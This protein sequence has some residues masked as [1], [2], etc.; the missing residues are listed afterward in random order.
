MCFEKVSRTTKTSN[1]DNSFENRLNEESAIIKELTDKNS[2]FNINDIMETR[3]KKA[4]NIIKEDDK[5]VLDDISNAFNKV[6]TYTIALKKCFDTSQQEVSKLTMKSNHIAS[7]NNRQTELWQESTNK[8]YMY[9]FE[10]INL[11][12]S[13]QHE[14][15]NSKRCSSH[16]MNNIE[17]LLHTLP[18]V[19]I[20]LN[21]NEGTRIPNLKVLEVENSQLK[22]EL[23][24]S[25][26][27]FKPSMGQALLKYV[28]KLKEWP[29]LSGEGEY[30]HM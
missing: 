24:T 28:P 20:P 27:N 17:Q 15:R 1:N 16:K 5:K 12:Q 25:F 10:V 3:I 9:K 4:I 30:D 21:Q 6:K 23:A 14:L 29:H 7:Y 8:E 11:I 18:R 13:F 22:N 19:S 2:K 26:D